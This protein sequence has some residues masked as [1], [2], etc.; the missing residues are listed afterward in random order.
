MADSTKYNLALR[1]Y[2]EYSANMRNMLKALLCNL[3]VFGFVCGAYG[4]TIPASEDTMGYG[5]ALSK[6]SGASASL[7]VDGARTSYLYFDLNDIPSDAV[8]RWAKLRLFIPVVRAQGAG[9]GVHLVTSEWNEA[10]T[11]K[12]P[13][14][15]V[16]TL[17]VIEPEKLG[18]KRFVT[19]DVTSTVQ[20]WISGGTLNEGLAITPIIKTGKA[21]ASVMLTSKEGT[22]LGLPAEL[23]IEFKPAAES[24]ALEQLPASIK[25]LLS[26]SK[27]VLDEISQLPSALR[28]FLGPTITLAPSQAMVSGSL[29][30]QASGLGILNY[31]WMRNGVAV[32]TGTSAQLAEIGLLGGTYSVVVDNGFT[33]VTSGSV[34]VSDYVLISGGTLPASSELG[35]ASVSSFF[36]GKSEVTW[37]QW[38]AVRAWAMSHGY[39]DLANVG[40]G[41]GDSYPV[42]NVS[43]YDVVKWCNALSE[44]EG[45]TPVYQVD[46]LTYK[47]GQSAPTVMVHA[48]GYR[49]PTETEWEWAAR[50]G[51]KTHGYTYGGSDELNEVG[52]WAEN[53]NGMVHAIGEKKSN[54]LGIYDTSGNVWEWC[55]DAVD[56]TKRRLRGG[57]WLCNVAATVA[58]AYRGGNN[59]VNDNA[60]SL[61]S[62]GVGFRLARSLV[63]IVSVQGGTLPVGSHAE[64][65]FVSDF[66]IGKYEVTWGDWK[67]VREWAMAQG[68][69]DLAGV[70]AGI[71]DNY[72]VTNVSWYDVVKWCNAKSE[73]EGKT[74]V[75]QL[76]GTTVK[77]GQSEPTVNSTANGYRLPTEAEWEWA[78]RGGRH[79]LGYTYSGGNDLN[80]VGWYTENSSA[81]T[82]GVGTKVGNE[83]GI[84][85][86]SGNVWEWC[87]DLVSVHATRRVR[88]GSW[89]NFADSA[90]V[91]F[92]SSNIGIGNCYPDW[93]FS[94]VGFRLACNSDMVSVQGGTLPSDSGLFGQPVGDFQIGKTEVTWGEWKTVREWA[95]ANGYTDLVGVGAGTGDN[96]PVTNV[97]WY[98]VVKWCNAKSEKE[99]KTPVYQVDEWPYKVGQ[100]S[101]TLKEN[102]NG[103]RLP[104]ESEWEWAARG[105]RQT[106]GYVYSGSDELN[107]VGWWAGNSNGMVHSIGEKK[108]N[109]LGV[110][111]MSG[112]L[113][114]WC[115]DSIDTTNRRLRGGNWMCNVDWTV[116]VAD[117]GGIN[118]VNDN[119]APLRHGAVGFRIARKSVQ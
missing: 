12:Q 2:S 37:S 1:R 61:I 27:V 113:L 55:F 43:W 100:S 84:Y 40:G 25:S 60:P 89:L 83:L 85:D 105:G 15:D 97:S 34:R 111:D 18:S 32:A 46:G 68:Y 6:A 112:N 22:A 23:D 108:P 35:A 36:I 91:S 56:V 57:S 5:N 64:G 11:S 88:G 102:A 104:T 31:Q 41:V 72:P 54:E 71:G 39:S 75:Y 78:A 99:G 30:V 103:Y 86:M 19:V 63:D 67:L 49:L 82:K 101:S 45:K 3:V 65:Q 109:E 14:I 10:L 33:S 58:V 98:D 24:V 21:T 69:S 4:L 110:Y 42:M 29:L 44:M 90:T 94:H 62:E 50:G 70:G 26:P 96:Y 28:A 92:R 77:T 87:W 66:Q 9:L 119:P 7:S 118:N 117:R 47:I 53:S 20:S 73:R 115:F 51:N 79:T 106:H 93:R 76:K 74:P 114:E 13:T 80:V 48:N 8:V 52:W 116:A 81:G 59:W 107:E 95:V 38:K 17:G 16:G